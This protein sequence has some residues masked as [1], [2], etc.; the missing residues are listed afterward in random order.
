M[1]RKRRE[2]GLERGIE[3]GEET[4]CNFTDVLAVLV[5]SGFTIEARWSCC[6]LSKGHVVLQLSLIVSGSNHAAWEVTCCRLAS[7]ADARL[8]IESGPCR[9]PPPQTR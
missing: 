2:A 7:F 6:S 1:T 3:D 8:A 4:A 5:S 9:R